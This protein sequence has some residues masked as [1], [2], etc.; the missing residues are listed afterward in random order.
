MKALRGSFTTTR[1]GGKAPILFIL[2]GAL[3]G[4]DKDE[5]HIV[6]TIFFVTTLTSPSMLEECGRMNDIQFVIG[7]QTGHVNK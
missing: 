7:F 2:F 6:I 4:S 5:D 1:Q 3:K